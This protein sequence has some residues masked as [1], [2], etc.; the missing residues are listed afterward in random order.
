MATDRYHLLPGNP[1]PF[2]TKW[3]GDILNFALFS[4]H[5]ESVTL[6]FRFLDNKKL[7]ERELNPDIHRTGDVWHAAIDTGGKE[8][9][10][11][12]RI[13][14]RGNPQNQLSD[15]ADIIV[16]D[17]Y[18][19]NLL[20]RPWGT[21]ST[22]GKEPVCVTAR[23]IPFDWLDDR[24]LQTPPSE[25][26]IYELHVRGFTRHP[27]SR[28]SKPGTFHGV[29]E[30]I[31]YLQELGI[32]AVEFLPVTEWDEM[33]NKFRHP[34]NGEKLLNYWGYNPLSFFSLRSGLASVPDEV[35]NEFK[36]MVRSLHQ[37]GIEVILDLVFNHTGE[38]DNNGTT[39]GFR[40]I[41]NQ[42]YYLVDENNGEYLNYSGCGNT[43]NTNHPVVRKLIIDALRYFVSEFH[44]DGFRF[45]LAAIFNRDVDGTPIDRAPLVELIAEDPVL[46]DCKIIA[47][48][49]DATGLYQVGTFSNNPRWMEWNGK[50]RDD[51]RTFMSG[52]PGSIKN[53]A[54]RIAGS[55][56]LYQNDG[57]SPLN[58]IN[59]ITSHDGFTLYDLVSYDQ[60]HNEHNGEQNR[61]G[62]NHNMSWNSG[63]EGTIASA[64]IEKLRLRRMRT[65]A[66][67]LFFSQG[68]PMICSG[69]EWAKSQQGNNNAWCQDNEISWLNWGLMETNSDL[70]RFF[71]KCIQLRSRYRLFRRTEFFPEVIEPASPEPPEIIWQSLAPDE[72]DWADDNLQLG[73]RL[74]STSGNGPDEPS[75]LILVNG[76]R[77]ETKTF[78]IPQAPGDQA[79]IGW[80]HIIDTAAASPADF[81]NPDQAQPISAGAGVLVKPMALAVLQ[82]Q[83]IIQLERINDERK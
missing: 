13:H 47:E 52:H 28:V 40:A 31:P 81:V 43:V 62:D 22:A 34:I 60:K 66:A 5:A 59:F 2:G 11:G 72:H 56:D 1:L 46:R 14:S 79:R 12:Y 29:V 73:F 70:F 75:F 37:A 58:S 21:P 3:H 32:T 63:F 78:T 83:N 64:K 38:S 25:T 9:C 48:A 51:V 69:D 50:F 15:N 53:L 10:Y 18:C 44:I 42:I 61:D 77:S 49:W 16:I 19:R 24:P 8:I 36:S 76:S 39:S 6:V 68:V 20:S 41:D 23:P 71:Q 17:P 26:V 82:S 54:T 74:N 35:V 67:L 65:F 55:S 33:D 30:K 4:R 7:L 45:D 80:L 57:R 27:S